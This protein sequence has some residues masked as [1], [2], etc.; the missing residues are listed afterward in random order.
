MTTESAD[1]EALRAYVLMAYDVEDFLK[2]LTVMSTESVKY[3]ICM[4]QQS[5]E[6]NPKLVKEARELNTLMLDLTKKH[7]DSRLLKLM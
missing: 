3:L 4:L 1:K 6:H 7:L 5:L 2:Y